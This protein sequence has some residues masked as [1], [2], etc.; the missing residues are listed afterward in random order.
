MG[1]LDKARFRLAK[2]AS[3]A[4]GDKWVE[5]ALE[6]AG[7][8]PELLY[9]VFREKPCDN[10]V[11]AAM[12]GAG[13]YEAI[14]QAAKQG[15]R[16]PGELL[17][18]ALHGLTLLGDL[19][20]ADVVA[21]ALGV[22]GPP[23]G[24]P[25]YAYCGE[26]LVEAKTGGFTASSSKLS[27][28]GRARV[29]A[30]ALGS[31]LWRLVAESGAPVAS[32]WG[33]YRGLPRT[34]DAR[35]LAA[36]AFPE[37]G[38]DVVSASYNV[39]VDAR[40]AA[41]AVEALSGAAAWAI[42]DLAG[43]DPDRLPGPVKWSG[44]LPRVE[45]RWRPQGVVL[46][47]RPRLSWGVIKPYEI[48]AP[49]LEGE[50]WDYAARVAVRSLALRSGDPAA[51]LKLEEP[52][53]LAER[54]RDLVQGLA[55]PRRSPP[56]GGGQVPAWIARC[57][58]FRVRVDRLDCISNSDECLSGL[59]PDPVGEPPWTPCREGSW[60]DATGAEAPGAPEELATRLGL[61]GGGVSVKVVEPRGARGPGALAALALASLSGSRGLVVAFSWAVVEA[62][63]RGGA[64]GL[65]GLD[66]WLA[67]SRPLV[68]HFRELL[69]KPAVLA[70]A[71]DVVSVAPEAWARRG[72]A[73]VLREEPWPD[74][75][76]VLR[77]R[78]AEFAARLGGKAVSRALAGLDGVE[79]L[80]VDADPL[81]EPGWRPIVRD[82]LEAF[83]EYWG[84]REPRNGQLAAVS[85]MAALLGAGRAGVVLAVF[86]TGYGKS[87]VFQGL[88]RPLA[89]AGYG[90]SVLVVTPLRALMRDQVRGALSR[91]IAAV[92]MES[93]L[94][95][96]WRRAAAEMARLGLVDLIYVAP[97]RFQDPLLAGG[98]EDW[99]VIVL[100][101]A[102]SLSRWG[103]T[104]RPAYLYAAK[105][106]Q[107]VRAEREWPPILALTATA[108][109][110]VED[111]ILA[112]TGAGE[113]VEIDPSLGVEAAE[114]LVDAGGEAAVLRL[115]PVRPELRFTV[116]PAPSGESRLET[117]A[118]EVERLTRWADSLGEPWIG[119]V[120]TGYVKSRS[121]S[122]ANAE[123]VGEFLSRRL[124]EE[125]AVYHG[126]LGEAARRRV[127]E[128]VLNAS[129][130]AGGPRIVVATKAFG[131]GVDIPNIRW[132]IH[133]TPSDSVE[134]YLQEAGRAGRDGREAW[135]LSLYSPGD[136]E[137]KRRRVLAEHTRPSTVLEAFNVLARVAAEL[138]APVAVAP[139]EALPG[140]D[141]G[142]RALD[143]LRASGVLEYEIHREAVAY[144]SDRIDPS[145]ILPWS[146]KLPGGYV[147]GPPIYRRSGVVS[148]RSVSIEYCRADGAG[149]VRL[150][151]GGE[152]LFSTASRCG[153]WE[154]G[155]RGLVLAWWSPWSEPE[156]VE[157]L[158]PEIMA[159]VLR[160]LSLESIKVDS[161]RRLLE[162]GL[163]AYSRGGDAEADRVIKEGIRSY[164]AKPAID[165]PPSEWRLPEPGSVECR[166]PEEC[167]KAAAGLAVELHRYLGP[168]GYTIAAQTSELA[169]P[170]AVAVRDATGEAP[171]VDPVAA[172]RRV[173]ARL[174][175]RGWK[176]VMDYGYLVV[177]ARSGRHIESLKSRLEGYP[178]Y[179]IYVSPV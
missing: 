59:V 58:G 114:R 99:A 1:L 120:F 147:L 7:G 89:A 49:Q 54:L 14:A 126:Q 142:V 35:L 129:R 152:T 112:L 16:V 62:A 163:A 174:R 20:S 6:A 77:L 109:P 5:A 111:E 51:A 91:G 164:F 73:R 172:Y 28:A 139:L 131:M 39:G 121:E 57:L 113:P 38:A 133:L 61:R 150:R 179:R 138:D 140:G 66:E 48:E 97:E 92:R 68:L 81:G 108:P 13:L 11:L 116:R 101:E 23:R 107:E 103:Y 74:A 98:V 75:V 4:L 30:E 144:K 157:Y 102:H 60:I 32:L 15:C 132:V 17:S 146:L 154:K 118:G 169:G 3:Q 168:E 70:W 167:V 162:E 90:S 71:G 156:P 134:D 40:G 85:A 55:R 128:A 80:R 93:G 124:G 127:E 41:E 123:R 106:L 115:D 135:A 52:A 125:V 26:G 37:A 137:K 10:R 153:S 84:G 72:A 145:E 9:D 130:G 21:E 76:K 83:R 141:L 177:V 94:P 117:L 166:T 63:R 31:G 96:E 69:E 53:E 56:R 161:L 155:V 50:G 64:V 47:D 171:R 45:P 42:Y 24:E 65:E 87:A 82:Y 158:P 151:V 149:H 100:D 19:D 160:G 25:L 104:F 12:A 176:G 95:P 67:G 86:P 175:E 165:P 79:Y 88:A 22:S 173:Q 110:D 143:I 2:W 170:L 136:F 43:A 8:D 29:E 33:C 36:I 34:V 119:V 105:R 159:A 44:F 122:W 27:P 178:Y 148:V 46:T 78:V 18:E